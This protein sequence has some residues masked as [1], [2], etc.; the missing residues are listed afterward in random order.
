MHGGS[1]GRKAWNMFCEDEFRLEVSKEV[2]SFVN[3]SLG[4]VV[5]RELPLI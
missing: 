1:K 5:R 3:A 4:W 2:G